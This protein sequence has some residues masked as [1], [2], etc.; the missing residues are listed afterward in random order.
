MNKDKYALSGYYPY[1]L[2]ILGINASAYNVGNVLAENSD[3]GALIQ[4]KLSVSEVS[5]YRCFDKKLDCRACRASLL[6]KPC[7]NH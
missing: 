3:S 6:S 4:G 7:A 2:N 1:G 5:F